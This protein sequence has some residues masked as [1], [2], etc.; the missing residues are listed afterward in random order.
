MAWRLFFLFYQRVITTDAEPP[1]ASRP[2]AETL[3][4]IAKLDALHKLPAQLCAS[5]VLLASS[6]TGLEVASCA[7]HVLLANGHPRKLQQ[8]ALDNRH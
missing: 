3:A 8:F 5:S 4:L 1:G 2:P 7:N 6:V